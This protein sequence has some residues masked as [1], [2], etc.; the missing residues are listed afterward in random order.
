[1]KW[2]RFVLK[3]FCPCGYQVKEED[4]NKKPTEEEYL[5]Q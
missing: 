4:I 2:D 1:M 3:F 5:R